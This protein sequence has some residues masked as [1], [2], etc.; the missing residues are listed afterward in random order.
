MV[1]MIH[2]FAKDFI[3]KIHDGLLILIYLL[4]LYQKPLTKYYLKIFYSK[5]NF[6]NIT[7]TYVQNMHT[8]EYFHRFFHPTFVI[9]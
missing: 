8:F 6:Y 2:K 9:V 4:K 3:R 5:L 1:C 7:F